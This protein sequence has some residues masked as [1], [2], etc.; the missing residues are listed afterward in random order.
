MMK[1][2]IFL[3]AG[4]GL[5]ACSGGLN[6]NDPAVEQLYT[7]PT[8][9]YYATQTLAN[10]IAANCDSYAYDA[11]LDGLLNEARNEVGRG[12]LGAR[13]Q[14]NAIDLETDVSQR[15]FQAKH[16]VNLEFDDLCPAGDAEVLEGTALSAF[17]KPA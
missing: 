17:L 11:E 15:S 6:L 4:L 5:A 1:H 12:S 2:A 8:P 13:A 10:K 3:G 14:R 7:M 9:Q 16:G